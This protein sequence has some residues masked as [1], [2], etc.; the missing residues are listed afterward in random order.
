MLVFP[1]A[2]LLKMIPANCRLYIIDPQELHLP[3]SCH[4]EFEHIRLGASEGIKLLA[5][6]LDDRLNDS[7]N[8]IEENKYQY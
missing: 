1:A 2:D 6:Q 8:P 4:H 3:D 7:L 5:E